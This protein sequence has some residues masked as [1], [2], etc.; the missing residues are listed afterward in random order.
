M[1]AHAATHSE[2]FEGD[3]VSL[4]D[5]VNLRKAG[6]VALIAAAVIA[7]LVTALPGAY[8]AVS[9]GFAKLGDADIRWLVLA[10]GLEALSFLGHNVLFRGVFLDRSSRIG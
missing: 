1:S 8:A 4:R 7:A 5:Q 3:S 10:L 6:L 9:D 2:L